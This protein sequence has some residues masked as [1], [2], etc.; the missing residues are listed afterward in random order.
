[1]T[2]IFRRL[3]IDTY[4]DEGRILAMVQESIREESRAFWE[5]SDQGRMAAKTVSYAA[6]ALMTLGFDTYRSSVENPNTIHLGHSMLPV[7]KFTRAGFAEGARLFRVSFPLLT[8]REQVEQID[9]LDDT[10]RIACGFE[11]GF[12]SIPSDELKEFTRKMLST[13]IE[14]WLAESLESFAKPVAADALDYFSWRARHDETV[15]EVE[16]SDELAEYYALVHPTHHR[17]L[18]ADYYADVARQEEDG[19]SYANRLTDAAEPEAVLDRWRDWLQ[20]AIDAKGR[21]PWHPSLQALFDHLG[22]VADPKLVDRVAEHLRCEGG[23]LIG[24]ASGL[25][26]AHLTRASEANVARWVGSEDVNARG[27]LPWALEGRTDEEQRRAF[28][29]LADDPVPFVRKRVWHRLFQTREESAWRTELLI[30]LTEVDQPDELAALAREIAEQGAA[31]DPSLADKIR[32]KVLDSA[33]AESVSEHAVTEALRQLEALGIDA[34]FDWIVRRLAWVRAGD[35]RISYRDVPDDV[36]SLLRERTTSDRFTRELTELVDLYEEEGLPPGYRNAL[37][38]AIGAL[39]GDSQELTDLVA[40]WATEEEAGLNRAYEV[41]DNPSSFDTFTERARI[42]LRA[43]NTRRTR[44]TI[45]GAQQRTGFSSGPISNHY[46]RRAERFRPWLEQD[47]P[48][49]AEL[50]R[51]AIRDLEKAAE[52]QTKREALEEEDGW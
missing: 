35:R 42:L 44:A 23:Q 27:V 11:Q 49:L 12:G 24:F 29:R 25:I 30:D 47:D 1:V 3:P 10:V 37:A 28:E 5:G 13:E 26:R 50:A 16:A 48:L 9:A 7:S 38:R 45:I 20:E 18:G 46:L 52:A 19:R 41:V 39:G 17:E 34:T 8:S 14:P 32:Q 51:E 21:S 31:I 6:R 43:G 2:T 33:E 22:E 40:R 4:E 36:I 15:S